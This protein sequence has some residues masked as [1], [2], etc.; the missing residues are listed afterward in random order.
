[1]RPMSAVTLPSE[2]ILDRCQASSKP[3]LQRGDGVVEIVFSSATGTT[4]LKHLYQKGPCRALF[5]QPLPG[6][7]TTAVVQPRPEAL[8]EGTG[9]E[10]NWLPA[11]GR[12]Q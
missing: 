1:M 11:R 2:C 3:R 5:P 10:S 6:D 8:R 12:R 4:R 9:L 7:L